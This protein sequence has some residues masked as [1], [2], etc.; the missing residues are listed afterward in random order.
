VSLDFEPVSYGKKKAPE[1]AKIAKQMIRLKNNDDVMP[2]KN[3][4]D[5]K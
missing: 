1:G 3:N 2:L 5:V 4:D